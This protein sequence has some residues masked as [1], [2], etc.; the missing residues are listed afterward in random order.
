MKHIRAFLS[1]ARRRWLAGATL[2]ILLAACGGGGG[3]GGIG[4]TGGGGGGGGIGGTGVAYGEITGFGS[5]WVNGVRYDTSSASFRKDGDTVSQSDLRVGMVAR[6]EGSATAG[7]A[8]LVSVD[9]ALKGRVEQATVDGYVVMGQT[10]RVDAGTVF[11]NNLRPAAGDIVEVHGLPQTTGVIAA[12][13]IERKSSPATPPYAVTGFVSAHDGAASTFQVGAL[14][15]AYAGA[16]VGD[17]P[18]GS[19]VGLV[20]EAKGS[21]CAGTPVCGTL[22]ASKVEPAGPRIATSPKAEV[23]GFVSAL[24][25]DGFMLGAQR[26]IVNASTAYEDGVVTDL[27]VGTKVEAEGPI[28]NGVMTATKVEFKAGVRIEADVLTVVGDRLTLAG[29]P[30]IE[31]QI[32]AQTELKDLGSIADVVPGL[33]VRLRGRPVGETQV[34]ATEFEAR[35]PNTDVELR[36]SASSV[37]GTLI[38]VLGVTIDTTGL[39]DSA[40]RDD[41]AVIGRT[42]F[43]TGLAGGRSL[44]AQGRRSG[45]AVIWEELELE[46]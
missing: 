10:V 2:T 35:S 36:G 34:V 42:A 20:V 28:S 18:T 8:T 39:P 7:T 23:E 16:D 30:G 9:S 17:M 26:V 11:D 43:F 19:W 12:S 13:Y 32:T 1:G 37:S 40:F 25:A 21:T 24:T 38:T 15:V 41:D 45:N 29:L 14:T 22:T 33:H 4:G 31:V 46:D 6:I 3:D 44:Q 5:V 27:V